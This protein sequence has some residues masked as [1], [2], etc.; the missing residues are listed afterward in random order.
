MGIKQAN[1]EYKDLEKLFDLSQKDDTVY[2]QR[3]L[4]EIWRHLDQPIPIH[5]YSNIEDIYNAVPMIHIITLCFEGLAAQNWKG[6]TTLDP[7]A[8]SVV[9]NWSIL[10]PWLLFIAKYVEKVGPE[11]PES[12][13]LF[14]LVA[15]I[16]LCFF[17]GVMNPMRII[18]D[19][20]SLQG[21]IP[22]LTHIWVYD[23]R[24]LTLFGPDEN[25]YVDGGTMIV[26]NRM[27]ATRFLEWTEIMLEISDSV[28][29]CLDA[30][31]AAASQQ[32]F[33]DPL[34]NI[35][36]EVIMVATKPPPISHPSIIS[37]SGQFYGSNLV[38]RLTKIIILWVERS[39]HRWIEA[40]TQAVAILGYCYEKGGQNIILSLKA[41]I[42]PALVRFTEILR[43]H[44]DTK[45]IPHATQYCLEIV[46]GHLLH[47]G[48]LRGVRRFFRTFD[49]AGLQKL[50]DHDRFE[51]R[52]RQLRR[53]F[54]RRLELRRLY[55]SE[56][57]RYCNNSECT[58]VGV[59]LKNLKKCNNCLDVTYCSHRCQK[60]DW[61]RHRLKCQSV[62]F[63]DRPYFSQLQLHYL[64]WVL[65][66]HFREQEELFQRALSAKQSLPVVVRMDY[67]W[68][69]LRIDWMSGEVFLDEVEGDGYVRAKLRSKTA[70][71]KDAILQGLFPD[72]QKQAPVLVWVAK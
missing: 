31:F 29:L 19:F 58:A 27:D 2:I 8:K 37:L 39:E 69:S 18:H 63:V 53:E 21:L 23:A 49:E 17:R 45:D 50:V 68:T 33:N 57:H 61:T 44:R 4:P 13:S 65:G 70:K 62:D 60:Q 72:G 66:R 71:G 16:V 22:L 20:N 54:A 5:L 15:I 35:Y 40:M 42:L 67:S 55:K 59:S 47:P 14:E 28:P 48:I 1:G 32:P 41:G 9:A 12:R 3:L 7:F 46:R 30:L 64:R 10:C 51:F 56:L 36:L 11:V 34:S 25:Q 24:R 26:F 38:V 52:W 43:P 6:P